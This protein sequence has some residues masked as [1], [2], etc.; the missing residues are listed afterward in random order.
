MS[1]FRPY[2]SYEPNEAPREAAPYGERKP[3][4]PARPLARDHMTAAS[5]PDGG[6]DNLAAAR[7]WDEADYLPNEPEERPARTGT[8]AS[9]PAMAEEP[10]APPYENPY[11]RLTW[12]ETE[13][14]DA[15]TPQRRRS[16]S[17]AYDAP[18]GAQAGASGTGG[19]SR[20]ANPYARPP[21]D[22]ADGVG[23][24]SA[25]FAPP[26][27]F[28][29]PY[30]HITEPEDVPPA[31]PAQPNVYQTRR[32]TVQQEIAQGFDPMVRNED[33]HLVEDAAPARRR[34]RARVLRR[35]LLALL[36]I[37][38]LGGATYLGRDWL[39]TQARSLLGNDAVET[40]N[41][42]MNQAIGNHEQAVQGF[43]PAPALQAGEA[44]KRGINAVAGNL[45]LE[46]YAVTEENVVARSLNAD[47]T[48]DYYLFAAKDG[49]LLGYY[50][51]IA[52]NGFLVCPDH[53]FYVTESPYLINSKGL[54]LIDASRYQQAAGADAVLGSIIGG[55]SIISD[56]Q[57]K[58]FNFINA[59]GDTLS[60]LWF[61]KVYPF[62]GSMT[63]AYMDTG[64]VTVPEERY[65][66]YTLTRSGEM[67]LWK[68]APD[69]EDVVGCAAGMALMANGDLV[70]LETKPSVLF[71]CDEVTVYAD[72]GAVVARDSQTGKVGL[73]V[74]GELH[75]DFAYDSITP[76][77]AEIQWQGEAQ[78]AFRLLKVTGMPYP[79]PLSHYFALQKDDAQEMVA[80]SSISVYPMLLD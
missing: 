41:Q 2:D 79:L 78:G 5:N 63:L 57:G 12:D 73:F 22:A 24:L 10:P 43:D 53:A 68:H 75:Y 62:T 6:Q 16:R 59:D 77:A 56:R 52:D 4:A 44:A 35:W 45:E 32:P 55:W 70:R 27:K 69:M 28:E 39:L 48:Y 14:A 49:Q 64:N 3:L 33:Y 46:S 8:A 29:L 31:A 38:V 30:T 47:G 40:V 34:R 42:M 74:H 19:V 7:G 9:A 20:T 23:D 21:A 50:E 65:A 80:L 17:N 18:T 26:L 37:A 51:R 60:A 11:S 66:L 13:Y 36:V 54:P 67:K 15:Q 25:R 71:Q 72:C 1:N 58:A 61:S 76:I